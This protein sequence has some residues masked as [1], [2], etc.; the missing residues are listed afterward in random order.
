MSHW[1]R[2]SGEKVWVVPEQV[3]AQR[4][5]VA[6]IEWMK[7]LF[8]G[9]LHRAGELP[10]ELTLAACE[11]TMYIGD[12]RGRP[13]APE[14]VRCF[15]ASRQ[16]AL[17]CAALLDTPEALELG[18]AEDLERGHELLRGVL[19]ILDRLIRPPPGGPRARRPA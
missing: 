7:R 14:R 5:A 1:N 4:A 11:M 10:H 15:R 12:A 16:H 3:A 13:D 2:R 19:E 6:F 9:P 8:E 18:T 17:R